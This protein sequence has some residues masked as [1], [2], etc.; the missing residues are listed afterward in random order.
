M[1]NQPK[2][3]PAAQRWAQSYLSNPP[4]ESPH[5]LYVVLN[6]GQGPGPY[7]QRLF[8]PLPV[9]Y[10]EHN[11]WG[12]DVGAFQ[13]AADRLDCDLMICFGSHVHFHRAGWLDRIVR[14]FEDNGPALY[15]CW[16]LPQPLPHIRTTAFFLPPDLLRLYPYVIGDPQR[17]E[18]EHGHESITLWCQKNGFE[19]Y[20]VTFSEVLPMSRWR[21]AG[22]EDCLF[23]DQHMKCL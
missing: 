21:H 23:G 7:Q 16:G 1:L 14:A 17:Y 2:Y 9:T 19:T 6:G 3:G 18:F 20:M 22:C 11:N 10:L 8:S 13:M 12:K 5:D 15:G 4:G